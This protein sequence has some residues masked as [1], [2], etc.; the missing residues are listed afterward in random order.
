MELFWLFLIT[1]LLVGALAYAPL[2]RQR[3]NRRLATRPLPEH[4]HRWL[5]ERWW[6]YPCLPDEVRARLDAQLQVM[7]AN[8]RF[9]GCN[10]LTVTESMRVLTLAQAALMH[11]GEGRFQWAGFPVVLLYPEAFV[12]EG[13]VTD[14]LGL[15]AHE[16]QELLGESW[17]QGKVVLSWADIERD[18]IGGD[19]H[20][21]VVHEHAHQWDGADGVMDGVPAL[22]A[23]SERE[24]FQRTLGRA[25]EDLCHRLDQWAGEGEPLPEQVPLDPYAATNPEEFFAVV[26]EYFFTD[27]RW[28][29]HA[30]PPVYRALTDLYRL[31]PS[32]WGPR[33]CCQTAQSF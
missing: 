14:E 17:E 13:E 16:R 24:H 29:E 21:L 23:G 11:V 22:L 25:F 6:L 28:L 18:L 33:R 8:T 4:W 5:H 9:F 15:V 26:S 30:Y 27:P 10:G 7:L 2:R 12:R 20:C 31:D 19:A 1:A 32:S 3:R